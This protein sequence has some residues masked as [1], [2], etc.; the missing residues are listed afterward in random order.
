MDE[1]YPSSEFDQSDYLKVQHKWVMDVVTRG[2][3]VLV[4]SDPT[5]IRYRF[6]D[7]S[8]M[9]RES[10]KE[11]YEMDEERMTVPGILSRLKAVQWGRKY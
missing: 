8:V 1:K 6:A 5:G 2:A 9:D 4:S 10:A 3:R 11:T 7:K